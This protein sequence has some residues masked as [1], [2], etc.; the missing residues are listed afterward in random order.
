[1]G[2]G[3]GSR[4]TPAAAGSR[5]ARRCFHP[6][7]ELRLGPSA[8]LRPE[9]VEQAREP[10][11]HFGPTRLDPFAV[12][13]VELKVGIMPLVRAVARRV[14]SLSLLDKEG[15]PIFRLPA[16]PAGPGSVELTRADLS[17]VLHRK[18]RH[19]AA[20]HRHP[21]PPFDR[22][23]TCG[24]APGPVGRVVLLGDAASA[25]AL[26][27]DGSSLAI[28]GAHTPAEALAAHPGDHAAAFRAYEAQH[29]RE[30][31]PRQE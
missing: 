18:A 13:V 21:K 10:G 12:L 31:D 9:Q 1:V 20:L 8:E 26:F 23:A 6:P 27:G 15:R 16:N 2:R 28:A 5:A 4:E 14:T 17:T 7:I 22:S 30:T 3:T 25:A 24:W 11:V 29:R 19:D